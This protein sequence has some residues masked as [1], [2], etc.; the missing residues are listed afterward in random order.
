MFIGFTLSFTDGF[1]LIVINL[2]FIRLISPLLKT[3]NSVFAVLVV[4]LC[5]IG[6]IAASLILLSYAIGYVKNTEYALG[7]FVV[8]VFF[9]VAIRKIYFFHL[10]R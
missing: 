9:S 1:S 2:A 10:F 4:I 6:A 7:V 3:D 5:A 8:G